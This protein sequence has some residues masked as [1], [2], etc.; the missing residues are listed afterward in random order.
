MAVKQD[1]ECLWRRVA[2]LDFEALSARLFPWWLQT[3]TFESDVLKEALG[4]HDRVK[5]S[6]V[7]TPERN[8]VRPRA[9]AASTRSPVFLPDHH[10]GKKK[11]RTMSPAHTHLK[12][13]P[14]RGREGPNVGWP[15][16]THDRYSGLPDLGND[17]H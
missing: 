16:L 7:C 4:T 17:T 6:N 13:V 11:G 1:R 3:D 2:S 5:V 14:R 12:I 8:L 10:G 15:T 9:S